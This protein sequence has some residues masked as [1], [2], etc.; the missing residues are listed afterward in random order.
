[1][2]ERLENAPSSLSLK[3]T[4]S[5]ENLKLYAQGNV[6]ASRKAILPIINEAID[7]APIDLSLGK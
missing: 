2:C 6:K 5:S 7:D 1:M 4:S 3:L